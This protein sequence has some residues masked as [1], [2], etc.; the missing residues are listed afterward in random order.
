M[1]GEL[2]CLRGRYGSHYREISLPFFTAANGHAPAAS[3]PVTPQKMVSYAKLLNGHAAAPSAP[4]LDDAST[5][6]EDS[7]MDV[8][9]TSE[10]STPPKGEIP[11][12]HGSWPHTGVHP[13]RLHSWIL[14]AGSSYIMQEQH[15]PNSS[16]RILPA[17]SVG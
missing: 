1:R 14:H 7:V 2:A 12:L 8:Q 4:Q 11:I 10:K 15:Q 5:A 13:K 3:K 17:K 16:S 6:E 9:T